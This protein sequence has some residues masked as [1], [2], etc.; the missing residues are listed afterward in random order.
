MTTA[1]PPQAPEVITATAAPTNKVQDQFELQTFKKHF[2][3]KKPVAST[4]SPSTTNQ[5]Q[6]QEVSESH[7]V[8][9]VHRKY[10][11]YQISALEGIAA[12]FRVGGIS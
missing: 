2:L 8:Q 9:D 7:T 11:E 12:D 6:D 3:V 10:F 1:G 5:E 4:K